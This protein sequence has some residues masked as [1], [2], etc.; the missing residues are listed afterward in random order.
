MRG[1][2]EK[3]S[4]C[5]TRGTHTSLRVVASQASSIRQRLRVVI[6]GAEHAATVVGFLRAHRGQSAPPGSTVPGCQTVLV[7]IVQL[8]HTRIPHLV[9]TPVFWANVSL[10]CQ[11]SSVPSQTR[12]IVFAEHFRRR[13]AGERCRQSFSSHGG[14][15]LRSLVSRATSLSIAIHPVSKQL[16]D[17]PS[18]A[19]LP[20][21]D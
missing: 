9:A 12:G 4:I 14:S 11:D 6:W 7:F 2:G 19:H 15:A 5:R 8:P 20:Y 13:A 16:R 17:D 10:R 21:K 1:C 3:R 18:V